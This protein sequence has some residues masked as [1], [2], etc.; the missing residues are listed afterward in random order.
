M[1]HQQF[2][3]IQPIILERVE[4]FDF[5]H[6]YAC[7][8][9]NLCPSLHDCSV[10]KTSHQSMMKLMMVDRV[11]TFTPSSIAN[12]V[13]VDPPVPPPVG[14]VVPPVGVAT[15]AGVVVPPVGSFQLFDVPVI[16]LVGSFPQVDPVVPVAL[17]PEFVVVVFFAIF[18]RQYLISLGYKSNIKT[19]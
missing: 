9:M 10:L 12:D 18:Q 7:N 19:C 2:G 11:I 1:H 13:L 4:V 16:P 5:M 14:A 17:A 6:T 15:P 8:V 3:F